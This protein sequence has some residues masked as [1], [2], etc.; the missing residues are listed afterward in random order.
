MLYVNLCYKIMYL[1]FLHQK[2]KK[3]YIYRLE[4]F[5]HFF[6]LLESYCH[7]FS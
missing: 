7:G 4:S 3:L 2:K 6:F 1:F 5:C